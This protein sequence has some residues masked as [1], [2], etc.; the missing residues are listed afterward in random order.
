M[1]RISYPN[2]LRWKDKIKPEDFLLDIGCWSGD[3]ILGLYNRCHVFGMD[4]DKEKI[5]KANLIIKDR[6]KLGDVTK[7]IPFKKKFD[8]IL[9]L[10]VIEHVNDDEKALKNISHSLKKDGRLIL[11]TPH[12]IRYFE[13]WDPA[14]IRWKIR[15]GPIHRHYS[16]KKIEKK[17]LI[18][19][20]KIEDYAIGWGPDFIWKRWINIFLKYVLK[21]NK[22]LGIKNQDGFFDLCIIARKIK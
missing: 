3:N 19:N 10:E 16:I 6:I 13:F 9:L 17:M 7:N 20:L 5:K 15:I 18:N 4:I 12:S 14:W 1:N 22:S 11:S 8:Y 2:F 21:I